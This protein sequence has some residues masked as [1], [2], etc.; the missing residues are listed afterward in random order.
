MT[1]ISLSICIHTCTCIEFLSNLKSI[2]CFVKDIKM[3]TDILK[4]H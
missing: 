4:V 2:K 3:I 1:K